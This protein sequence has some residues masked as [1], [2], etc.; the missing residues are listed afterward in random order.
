MTKSKFAALFE[1][2]S[3]PAEEPAA[4]PSGRVEK[5]PVAREA[6]RPRGARINDDPELEREADAQGAAARQVGRPPGKRSDPEWKQFSVLLKKQTQAA[7]IDALRAG[8]AKGDD[9]DL[10]RLLQELLEKWLAE[11]SAH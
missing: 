4:V 2:A 7:A 9:R 6:A 3:E 10:S 11:R 1:Q 5:A 8:R